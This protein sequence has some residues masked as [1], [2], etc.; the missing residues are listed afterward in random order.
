MQLRVYYTKK[1]NSATVFNSN[2][3]IAHNETDVIHNRKFINF[4]PIER[5]LQSV[6]NRVPVPYTYIETLA[7]LEQPVC[8]VY[9]Y[10]SNAFCVKKIK[11]YV[12]NICTTNYWMLFFFLFMNALILRM[13]YNIQ[14]CVDILAAM[15]FILVIADD[16]IM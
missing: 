10:T 5:S 8:A 9:T 7:Q 11:D 14:R 3:Y 12:G 4:L 13:A 15:R 2:F 1:I 16:C 6:H